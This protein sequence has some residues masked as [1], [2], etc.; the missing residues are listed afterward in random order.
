MLKRHFRDQSWLVRPPRST[1]QLSVRITQQWPRIAQESGCSPDDAQ[2]AATLSESIDRVREAR[3]AGLG[4]R[5][6]SLDTPTGIRDIVAD[7]HDLVHSEAVL[8]IEQAW[9]VLTGAERQLL[10]LRYW[11]GRSQGD[12]AQRIGTSQMQVS[13]LLSQTLDRIRAELAVEPSIPA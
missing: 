4:Y 9:Q 11:E 8:F 7:D 3:Q 10:H 6:V 5:G 2:L 12:I 1:Q 13:R